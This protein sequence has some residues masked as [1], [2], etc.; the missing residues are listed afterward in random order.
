MLPRL[1]AVAIL[2]LLGGCASS[3]PPPACAPAP[4]THL[5]LLDRG[6]HTELGIPMEALTGPARW[7]RQVFPDAR[8]LMVG[9][10]KKT[11]ITAPADTISEYVLGPLPGP[12]VLQ[13]AAL[14]VS[15][16]QAYPHD[17]M[18]ELPLT[19]EGAA[20]LSAA[21]WN[22]FVQGADGHPHLV[23]VGPGG[24][25]LFYDARH[26]YNFGHT[27]NAWTAEMLH[28]AGEPVTPGGVVLASQVMDRGQRAAA[29]SCATAAR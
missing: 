11:F 17:Q 27:C 18:I 16:D 21:L 24:S 25:S 12:A 2:M 6:W 9:Y 7:F 1:T 23:S 10:G 4:G 28:A 26:P 3:A 20:A 14:R 8:T 19:P 13:V 22:E 29:A 5:F 15:P